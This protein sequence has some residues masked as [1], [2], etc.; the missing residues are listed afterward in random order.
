MIVV[1]KSSSVGYEPF[2][3]TVIREPQ[4][5]LSEYPLTVCIRNQMGVVV[6][7]RSFVYRPDEDIRQFA[8][9]VSGLGEGVYWVDVYNWNGCT[10]P[11]NILFFRY[12]MHKVSD[13]ATVSFEGFNY[14]RMHVFAVYVYDGKLFWKYLI[15]TSDMAVPRDVPVYIEATDISRNAFVGSV[16]GSGTIQVRPNMRIPFMATFT[17]KLN[18]PRAR[19]VA[20]HVQRYVGLMHGVAVQLVDDYTFNIVITKTEPGIKPLIAFI[21]GAAFGAG[22]GFVATGGVRVV[23]VSVQGKA[24]ET[25]KQA[26]DIAEDAWQ[27]YTN[28]VEQCPP[29]D[30][31]CIQATQFK[32]LS[33]IQSLNALVGNLTLAGFPMGRV[34]CDGLNV[35]G[36]C[37]PWWMVGLIIFIAGL[38]VVAVLR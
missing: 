13:E 14:A 7:S 33:F 11:L 6:A 23:E 30:M 24:L 31:Q 27:R 2:Y 10:P 17:I 28:E 9:D 34:G 25:V 22:F 35:G 29:G 15:N 32:W 3:I 4:D 1:P 19:E 36:V 21:I 8:V 26:V 38:M 20:K 5:V 18:Q 12:L 16:R 37:I